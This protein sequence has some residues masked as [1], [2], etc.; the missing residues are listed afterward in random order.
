M[1]SYVQ[2]L[3]KRFIPLVGCL[4]FVYL[5]ST[6]VKELGWKSLIMHL[7][8]IDVGYFLV[9]L[10]IFIVNSFLVPLRTKI[11]Y[12]LFSFKIPYTLAL[13]TSID[14]QLMGLLFSFVGQIWGQNANLKNHIPPHVIAMVCLCERFF[15]VLSG[16]IFTVVS[17]FLIFPDL[18]KEMPSL[19]ATL[20]EITIVVA[21]TIVVFVCFFSNKREFKFIQ[22]LASPQ[23]L[24][25]SLFLLILSCL[26][27]GLMAVTFLIAL[28]STVGHLGSLIPLLG[29]GIIVSFLASL[30]ISVGGWGIRE[31]AALSV[32]GYL[33][34]AQ[35][36]ALFS[37]ISI[38]LVSLLAL[39]LM[40]SATL[41]ISSK[42]GKVSHGLGLSLPHKIQATH[43]SIFAY[44]TA[45]FIFFQVHF[46]TPTLTININL[47]DIFALSGLGIFI[48][49]FFLKSGDNPVFRIP[50]VGICIVLFFVALTTSLLVGFNHF[51]FSSWAFFSKFLGFFVLIGYS[52]IGMDFIKANGE[53][54]LKRIS[55]LMIST[56]SIILIWKSIGLS[57]TFIKLNLFSS[58]YSNA[59]TGF[60]ANRNAFAIQILVTLWLA[61]IAL[62]RIPSKEFSEKAQWV[63]GLFLTGLFLTASRSG[64]GSGLVLCF[65]LFFMNQVKLK[66]L[67]HFFIK[68]A[69]IVLLVFYFPVIFDYLSR[70]FD[71][72]SGV[73]GVSRISGVS[74]VSGSKFNHAELLAG[75]NSAAS[76]DTERLYTIIEGLKLW[77]KSPVFGEGLGAFLQNEL[78]MNKPP[79]IIHNTFVWIL[80]ELGLF[81]FFAF[82]GW[83]I[84]QVHHLFKKRFRYLTSTQDLILLGLITIFI[85]MS[86]V[87][88]ILYQRIL[89]FVWGMA[90]A[91][92]DI[93]KRSAQ[94]PLQ[95]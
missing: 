53:K 71:C 38:G 63:I 69:A 74:G 83:G 3:S 95:I 20:I 80:A 91:Q 22:L 76:S 64:I 30:P 40:S 88:E 11:I 15:L 26:S 73:S 27:W 31:F 50:Y 93:K 45:I 21:S 39:G 52:Y 84:N 67:S 2:G 75:F 62:T 10:G 18:L 41:L 33:G 55:I 37:S 36:A 8:A 47:S 42:T 92:I 79:L 82:L 86:M 35:S 34:I 12:S 72:L 17:A 29:A 78:L 66:D 90:I 24:K 65:L 60:S 19:L 94:N 51:G 77:L 61:F 32:F 23:N 16:G 58:V 28:K 7:S 44:A 57:L 56:L 6:Q 87:H 81:G 9:I 43:T 89:I 5:I 54:G 70:M 48:I 25:M 4:T 49:R 13:K 85:L 46:S 68:S 1:S 14:G 59:F